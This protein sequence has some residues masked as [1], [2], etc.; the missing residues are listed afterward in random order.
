[1]LCFVFECLWLFW[2]VVDCGF[3]LLF[4]LYLMFRL[5]C[6]GVFAVLN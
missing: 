4:R 5:A 3:D 1:M 6:N 2:V